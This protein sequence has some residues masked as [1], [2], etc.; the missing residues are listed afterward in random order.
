MFQE[1]HLNDR[2]EMRTS[3]DPVAMA[4]TVR[5]MIGDF[6]K[7]AVVTRVRF[8][9]AGGFGY[10]SRASHRPLSGF[11]GVLGA[12]LAGIGLYGLLAYSVARRTNEI[13]IRM[14]LGASRGD[15]SRLVL[16]DAIGML[17]AGFGVGGFMVLWGRPLAASLI[18]GLEPVS[19]RPLALA[20][21]AM[22]AVALLA[23]YV[24]CGAQFK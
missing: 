7:P 18:Q 10:C 24:R 21:G 9:R 1:N 16:R 20:G 12:A 6:L 3:A 2:F 4:D 17:C 23:S 15:V 19:S 13:G 5:R 8:V 14:A 22:A 11:F